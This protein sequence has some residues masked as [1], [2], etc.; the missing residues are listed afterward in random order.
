M[1]ILGKLLCHFYWKTISF[2]KENGPFKKGFRGAVLEPP[3]S[4][5]NDNVIFVRTE[6]EIAITGHLRLQ[7]ANKVGHCF[8]VYLKFMC[9]QFCRLLKF[10]FCNIGC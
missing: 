7:S 5:I 2:S 3:H 9:D 8:H 1:K 4:I 6:K 10:T